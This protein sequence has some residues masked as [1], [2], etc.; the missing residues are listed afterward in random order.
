MT[1]K[2]KALKSEKISYAALRWAP[3]F[4]PQMPCFFL[5][6]AH[7]GP[8][9]RPFRAKIQ[10]QS[11]AKKCYFGPREAILANFWKILKIRGALTLPFF[12][13]IRNFWN[14]DLIFV[15]FLHFFAFF[16]ISE[17]FWNFNTC[18]TWLKFQK[19]QNFRKFTILDPKIAKFQIFDPFLKNFEN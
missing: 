2:K 18:F 10:G 11:S 4:D 6:F 9:N 16:E 5:I 13:K 8:P 12:Q 19:F 15:I 14:F 7:F 1:Q 3:I 17:N